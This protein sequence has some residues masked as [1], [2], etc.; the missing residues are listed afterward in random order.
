MIPDISIQW[1]FIWVLVF[2]F[3]AHYTDQE[4]FQY[5]AKPCCVGFFSATKQILSALFKWQDMMACDIRSRSNK[6][7]L[8]YKWLIHRNIMGLDN[9]LSPVWHQAIVWTNADIIVIESLETN[10]SSI[11]IKTQQFSCKWICLKM[12][13][14]KCLRSCSGLN[15]LIFSF[16][17]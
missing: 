1:K 15:V 9:G 3:S 5:C 4:F 16:R 14:A 6:Y 7:F 10:F 12:T 11:W 13:S 17:P 8:H 2:Y